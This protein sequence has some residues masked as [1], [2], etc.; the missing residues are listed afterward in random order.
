MP[1]DDI[2]F[3]NE[4]EVDLFW[5]EGE[6]ALHIIDRGTCYSVAK[7]LKHQTSEYLWNVIIE[8]WLT[9]FTGFP[10]IIAHDRGNN[11][12]SDF[13]QLACAEFGINTS[14]KPTESHNSLSLCERYHSIIRRIF[15]KLRL[16]FP[17]MSKE[18]LLS[19]STHA[20]N[21]T[22]GSEGLTPSLLVFGA[23]P[24]LPI[25]NLTSIPPTQKQRFEAMKMAREEMYTITAERRIKQALLPGTQKPQPFIPKEGD[26]VRVYREKEMKFEGPFKVHAYDQRKT[27]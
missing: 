9:V 11:F 3:N 21:T 19:L 27:V 23:I 12:S 2:V 14:E 5:I 4:I 20:G 6:A 24:R 7:F 13:F 10:N 1:S 26:L 18:T 15:R 25:G 16:N 22:A 8:F 17:D